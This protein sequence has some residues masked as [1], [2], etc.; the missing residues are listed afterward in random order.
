VTTGHA[1]E[2]GQSGAP[3]ASARHSKTRWPKGLE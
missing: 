2:E 1:M 3:V